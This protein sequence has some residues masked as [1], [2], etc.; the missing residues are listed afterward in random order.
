M[1]R[2]ATIDDVPAILELVHG[3]AAYEKAPHEVRATEEQLRE[4][5]FRESPKVFAHLAEHEGEVVGFAV[6]FVS[7]STWRGT[8]GLYLEDLFVQPGVRG[9]GY[10]KALMAELAGICVERGYQR[11]EWA[12]LDWNEPSIEFYRRL[13]AEPM[14]E[15]TTY[16]L[17]D[18]PLHKL[19][20]RTPA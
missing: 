3:L 7:F 19:A 18:E 4:V 10:G 15:W 6:W 1:I 17:T 9:T 14:N 8:H 16:R 5:L 13:G 12:V 20:G 11:M 2:P